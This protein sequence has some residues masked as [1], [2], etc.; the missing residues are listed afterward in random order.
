MKRRADFLKKK[1]LDGV[2][3]LLKF[4]MFNGIKVKDTEK[5][6]IM[7]DCNRFFLEVVSS[8]C[9]GGREAPEPD[10]I[11]ALLDTVLHDTKTS[12]LSPYKEPDNTPHH[13]IIPPAAA[14]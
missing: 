4:N 7:R 3:Q 12:K 5:T 8:L 11:K 2:K 13:Q 14:S 9:F 1:T 10:L 6:K